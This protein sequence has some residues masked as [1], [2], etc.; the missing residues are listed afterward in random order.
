MLYEIKQNVEIQLK[1]KIPLVE[2]NYLGK[3]LEH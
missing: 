2:F 1:H 3:F